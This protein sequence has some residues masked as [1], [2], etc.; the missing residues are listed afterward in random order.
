MSPDSLHGRRAKPVIVFRPRDGDEDQTHPE[1]LVGNMSSAGG[2]MEVDPAIKTQEARP[3]APK[4]L[5]TPGA[6][7]ESFQAQ[8]T[9]DLKQFGE[10]FPESLRYVIRD[11]IQTSRNHHSG[12]VS[13]LTLVKIFSPNDCTGVH[14]KLKHHID[15][16]RQGCPSTNGLSQSYFR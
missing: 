6:T 5:T 3:R 12:Q 4:D 2:E 9:Q 10:D 11:E 16:F 8:I 14:S 1:E 13:T 15:H 7:L